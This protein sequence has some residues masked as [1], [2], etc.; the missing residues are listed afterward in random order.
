MKILITGGA[1]FIGSHLTREL[2]KNKSNTVISLDDFTL[3]S[4][5]NVLEF[6]KEDNFKFYEIDVTKIEDIL[7]VTEGETIDV[8][9]HLAANSDIQKCGQ[10]PN[11]DY[12]NTFLTTFSVLEYAR[13]KGI[14]KFFFSSTSAV[15]GNL[16]DIDLTEMQGGLMP[17]SYYGA[18]K[19]ASESFISA[20]TH[21]N[22]METVIFR[23]PNV[24]GPNLTHGVIFDFIRRLEQNPTELQILGDGTQQKPYIYVLDLVNGIVRFTENMKPGVEVYNVGVEGETTVTNI[25]NILCEEM[26]LANVKYNYTG[27]NIGWKGDVPRF[28]YDLSKIKAE[29]WNPKYNS[30]EA[31]RESIR[32][33]LGK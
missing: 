23:F 27:G 14:K 3:G 31:V 10:N 30:D 18:S 9:Y 7:K 13:I 1:G 24:I 17:I 29:G 25:A 32:K 2:L 8:I 4:K 15:Y 11:I 33:V 19:L 22:N 21:M 16:I 6:S 26:G 20:F 5:E 28:K 12:Y